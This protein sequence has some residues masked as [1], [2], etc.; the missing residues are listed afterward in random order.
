[1]SRRSR[2][3]DHIESTHDDTTSHEAYGDREHIGHDDEA[4][5]GYAAEE[6]QRDRFGGANWGAGFFGWLVAIAV[7]VLLAS[8]LGAVAA[9]VGTTQDVTQSQAESEAGTI[10]LVAAVVLLALLMIAYYIGGYVAG[11]MSRFDGGKQ[12]LAVWAIGLLVTIIAVVLGVVF[13]TQY[14]ILERVDLPTMPVPTD[15][16]SVGGVI[17]A[18]AVLLGT[19][20]A[21]MAGGKV[22]QRYHRK[23]DDAAYR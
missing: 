1:M 17:T 15:T 16:L 3:S 14:N 18:V 8:I 11:R 12:G 13:G 21:A 5:G 7:T 19:L 20:L 4:V 22:G 2:S 10:G 6:R 9:A 23:V